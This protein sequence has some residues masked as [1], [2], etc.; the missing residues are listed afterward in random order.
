MDKSARLRYR[1]WKLTVEEDARRRTAA[2]T[3]VWPVLL[4]LGGSLA[5]LRDRRAFQASRNT[6]GA[7]PTGAGSPIPRAYSGFRK[8][9]T[10]TI[11]GPLLGLGI[12]A[13]SV[14]DTSSAACIALAAHWGR[15][16]DVVLGRSGAL[17]GTPLAQPGG[18]PGR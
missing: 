13:T 6:N 16:L 9:P 18:S 15:G 17:I 11:L 7:R 14:L 3:A 2:R 10:P 1:L 12:M 5:V 4:R 8:I